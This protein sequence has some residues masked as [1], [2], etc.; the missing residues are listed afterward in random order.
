MKGY[1]E[2]INIEQC[3]TLIISAV[4]PEKEKRKSRKS[5]NLGINLA[6]QFIDKS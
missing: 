6:P 1:R 5:K 2:K 3:Q 4:N